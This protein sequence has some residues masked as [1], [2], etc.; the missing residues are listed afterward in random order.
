MSN[1]F[2]SRDRDTWG[3]L[4]LSETIYHSHVPPSNKEI[5]FHQNKDRAF[6]KAFFV[7]H[8]DIFN[9]FSTEDAYEDMFIT[10]WEK[11]FSK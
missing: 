3:I 4:K 9:V 11:A 1:T 6:E 2:A 5:Y 10:V 7:T 8:E